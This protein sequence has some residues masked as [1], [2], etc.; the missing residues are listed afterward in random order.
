MWI[1]ICIT[2]WLATS[3]IAQ[4]LPTTPFHFQSFPPQQKLAEYFSGYDIDQL[5]I[6]IH[7]VQ[8]MNKLEKYT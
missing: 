8:N 7:T 1:V 5:I 3:M 6:K 2:G 4:P